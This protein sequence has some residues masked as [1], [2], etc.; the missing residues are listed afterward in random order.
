M[1]REHLRRPSFVDGRAPGVYLYERRP[2][3]TA[4]EDLDLRDALRAL[5]YQH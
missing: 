2:S 4:A 3:A 5:G 1:T